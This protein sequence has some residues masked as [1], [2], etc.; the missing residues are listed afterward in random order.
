LESAHSKLYMMRFLSYEIFDMLSVVFNILL[1][2]WLLLF[3]NKPQ[4]GL[5]IGFVIY[6]IFVLLHGMEN[7]ST[8]RDDVHPARDLG[9]Q[10]LL[11]M[12]F[13]PVFHPR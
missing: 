13:Q 10:A 12:L 8:L 7:G 2:G 3:K 1:V 9:Y 11:Q 5:L 6:A 4:R